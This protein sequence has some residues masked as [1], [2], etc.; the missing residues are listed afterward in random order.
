MCN[1]CDNKIV[2]KP[3]KLWVGIGITILIF[4]VSQAFMYGQFTGEMKSHIKVSEQ[5]V[6]KDEIMPRLNNIERMLRDIINN[7]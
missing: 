4:I 3:W 1:N 6:S 5:Y 2:A 7:R